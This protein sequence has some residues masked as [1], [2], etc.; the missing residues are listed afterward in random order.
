MKPRVFVLEQEKEL[1][2]YAPAEVH[3][4]LNFVIKP[5]TKRPSIW[6]D[7]FVTEVISNLEEAGFDPARDHFVAVGPIVAISILIA[8]LVSKYTKV[9]VLLFDSKM[10][11]YR[12]TTLP[13]AL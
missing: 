3:G 5:N 8:S 1:N 13:K 2:F 12:A 7:R 4:E 6:D 9:S 11:G 10:G